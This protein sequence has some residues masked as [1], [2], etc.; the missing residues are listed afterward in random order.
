MRYYQIIE[1]DNDHRETLNKTG[2]WGKAGAGCIFVAKDTGKILLNHR[3]SMVEQPG[4]WGVWGGA[5]DGSESPLEAVK[6]EAYEEAGASPSDS[7]IIPIYIFHDQKSGFKYY[8]F[9][10]VVEEEF[11]PNIPIQSRWE[12]QGWGWFDLNDFPSPLHFGV[13]AILN[14]AGSVNKIKQIISSDE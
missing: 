9:I 12:T 6:R 1:N 10:V 11:K 14:D 2:F 8:N 7:Q 5:I 3:S 4:T 13:K